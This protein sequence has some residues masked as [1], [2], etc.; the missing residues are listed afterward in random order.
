MDTISISGLGKTYPRT[1]INP[2]FEALCDLSLTVG[3]GEVFGFIGPNGAGKSTTIKIL[4]GVLRPTTGSASLFG[5]DVSLPES[6]RGLGYVPENPSLYDYLTP[7]ELLA[8]GQAIHGGEPSS[9]RAQSMHW[10]ERFDLGSVANKRI[11]SF[12]KGMTQRVALAHAMAIRPRLLILDEP[13]SGLDPVGRKEVVDILAEYRHG[14]GTIFLTSHVLHDVERLADRF[15]LI[16]HGRMLTVQS[17]SSMLGDDQFVM[18]RSSGVL[19]VTG[20]I[21][22]S[23]GRWRANVRRGELWSAMDALRQARHTIL[24]VRPALALEDIFFRYVATGNAGGS[25]ETPLTC[26]TDEAPA[27]T[28][29]VVE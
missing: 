11:R 8:M 3:Q 27:T 19:P 28:D 24:E 1:W 7:L 26:H 14:G 18:V 25:T 9:I 10:L 21:P 5:Q 22:E 17:P 12:S 23:G 20:F 6:R 13:L 2:A 16:H 15:G 4:T 29:A